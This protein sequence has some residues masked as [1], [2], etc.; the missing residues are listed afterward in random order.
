MEFSYNL[1]LE[2][3]IRNGETKYLM[4]KLLEK[5]LPPDLVYRR[6]WGF[7]APVGNWLY[8][9]LSYLIDQWLNPKLIAKQGIFNEGE[10]KKY[11]DAFRSGKDFH[12]K[13]LW[14]VIIFQMWYH[15]YIE[16]HAA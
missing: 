4:K 11:I 2:Y 10:I 16:C 15:K 8:R 1:P 5:Y 6:K 14:S 3:K 12:Y 7:P 9:E 13:R